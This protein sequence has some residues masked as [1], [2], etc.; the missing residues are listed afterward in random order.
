MFL[1]CETVQDLRRNPSFWEGW[2]WKGMI[3]DIGRTQNA[4]SVPPNRE[5]LNVFSHS[6]KLTLHSTVLCFRN[7][8][9]VSLLWITLES[10]SPLTLFLQKLMYKLNSL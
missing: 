7:I 4:F 2:C 9:R 8:M 10:T 1:Q 5:T 3:R 6:H